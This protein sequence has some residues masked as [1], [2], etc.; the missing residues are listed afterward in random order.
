MPYW[1]TIL[2]GGVGSRFW[3]VST[4]KRPKQLLPLV[5]GRSLIRETLDR[6]LPAVPASRVL[7]LTGSHLAG[8]IQG[9]LPELDQGGYLVEP[10]ARGTAPVLAWAATEIARRDPGAVMVSLHA[11]HAIDPDAEFRQLLGEV[12]A[13]AKSEGFLFTIGVPPNRP[14]TGYGYIRLGNRLGPVM[15]AYH[16]ADFVEKPDRDTAQE[17]IRRRGYLWNSGIFVWRVDVLLSQLQEHTPELSGLL[18]LLAD[19]RVADFFERAPML[20]VDEGLLE[21][22][23][24][25]AVTP[26]TFRWDD[27]GA[28]DSLARCRPTDSRGNVSV[29]DSLLHESSECI[30]WAEDGTVVAFGTSDLVIVHLPEITLVLPRERA[31][32]LKELVA[33][34]PPEL[35]DRIEDGDG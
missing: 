30:T 34:L 17:Y 8:G 1:V 27:V 10:R 15:N 21:R 22:S 6:V 23:D 28:W 33:R 11:D 2:A 7:V 12:A 26:A 13:L 3:P 18:P 29:G 5:G 35:R 20:S 4:R 24:R 9:E 19:G 31:A 25:V 16:V 32:D 14:E